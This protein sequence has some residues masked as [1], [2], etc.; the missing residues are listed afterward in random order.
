MLVPVF[1]CVYPKGISKKEKGN[2]NTAM[3]KS[4]WVHL[5]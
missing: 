4:K 3:P 5:L 1:L 2:L